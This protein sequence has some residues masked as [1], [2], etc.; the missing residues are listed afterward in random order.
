MACTGAL[1]FKLAFLI[2]DG[3]EYLMSQCQLKKKFQSQSDLCSTIKKELFNIL[4]YFITQNNNNNNYANESKALWTTFS[5]I[6]WREGP[7][8]SSW[9]VAKL[10]SGDYT[11]PRMKNILAWKIFPANTFPSLLCGNQLIKGKKYM[12]TFLLS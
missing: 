3:F 8:V 10:G 9:I 11:A 1:T 12:Y 2:L 6:C 7:L 4:I 5:L